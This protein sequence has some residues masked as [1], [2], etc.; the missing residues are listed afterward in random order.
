M[1]QRQPGVLARCDRGRDA[2]H[3]FEFDAVLA[4]ERRFLGTSPEDK[5]IAAFQ[6]HDGFAQRSLGDQA[7]VDFVLLEN[8][9]AGSGR[10]AGSFA[11]S[12]RVAKQQ[13][14][15]ETVV[16][17]NVRKLKTLDTAQRDQSGIP[18][19]GS[20]EVDLSWLGHG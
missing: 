14:V 5:R 1:S 15:H 17:N 9:S 13:W 11:M 16:K 19:S 12:L 18:R 7:F 8:P 3:D 6:S 20:D 4:Q 10:A 2:W